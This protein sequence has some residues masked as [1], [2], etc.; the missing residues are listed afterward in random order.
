[1]IVERVARCSLLDYEPSFEALIDGVLAKLAQEPWSVPLLKQLREV[2]LQRIADGDRS[3]KLLPRRGEGN[4][5][6]LLEAYRSM[7]YSPLQAQPLVQ[8]VRE[9][10]RLED[11]L[12]E[13]DRAAAESVSKWAADL[14][15]RMEEDR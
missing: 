1:V 4:L 15:L 10:A 9:I 13:H 5:A 3:L 6:R 14:A 8:V 12:P 7:A 2:A 11:S